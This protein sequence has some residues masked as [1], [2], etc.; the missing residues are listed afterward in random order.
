MSSSTALDC[1]STHKTDY[2]SGK[3]VR[4][5]I[6]GTAGEGAKG[7]APGAR[8]R[9]GRVLGAVSVEIR[10]LYRHGFNEDMRE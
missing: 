5:T 7:G 4:E 6:T 2:T 3:F 10:D 9:D 8:R 1:S